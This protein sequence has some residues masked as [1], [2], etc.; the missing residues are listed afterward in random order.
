MAVDCCVERQVY[1]AEAQTLVAVDVLDAVG[2]Q[3]T[4]IVI[5]SG[6]GIAA[7]NAQGCARD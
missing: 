2:E 4:A 1:V 7:I 3:P 5:S 6:R